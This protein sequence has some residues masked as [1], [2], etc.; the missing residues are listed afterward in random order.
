MKVFKALI[1]D[2]DGT[3]AKSME[4]NYLAWKAA[5]FEHGAELLPEDYYP[6][7]GTRVKELADWMNKKFDLNLDNPEQ[8][9]E[10]KEAHY[11]ANHKFELYPGAATLV[12][13]LRHSAIPIAM[14]TAGSRRRITGSAPADFLAQFDAIVTAED[15][16]KGKPDPD[17]YL[18]GAEKLGVKIE[19]CLVIENAPLGVASAKRAGA[20]C[21]ALCTTLSGNHLS[22]A[23]KIVQS[24]EELL[25]SGM[26]ARLF[27]R[28]L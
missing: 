2:F 25:A 14:V 11:L 28:E 10:K 13:S 24:M 15:T 3:L 9:A 4:D 20:F 17:P 6:L 16:Q 1:F 21:I 26:L 22:R 8:L 19:E 7:E 5:A 18:K 27:N 12:R 23:D